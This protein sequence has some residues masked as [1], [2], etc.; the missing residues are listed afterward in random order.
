M[1]IIL[2]HGIQ[3]H[4]KGMYVH[5]IIL[6]LNIRGEWIVEGLFTNEKYKYGEIPDD[7]TEDSINEE[8]IVFYY[9]HTRLES[10]IGMPIQIHETFWGTRNYFQIPYSKRKIYK[11]EL[12]AFN[13]EHNYYVID[14]KSLPTK[15]LENELSFNDYSELVFDREQELK[16][17]LVDSKKIN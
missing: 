15:F 16:S 13:M 1:S 5:K 17:M 4:M 7:Y 6:N 8:E 14:F 11:D 2:F 9:L 10:L 12:M 3:T